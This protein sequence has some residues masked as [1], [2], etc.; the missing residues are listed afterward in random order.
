[1][2]SRRFPGKTLAPFRD[3]PV[4]RHVL[5]AVEDALPHTQIVVATSDDRSDDPLAA[6]LG[7]L[8]VAVFRGPLD[9]VFERFRL[10]AKQ[11]PSDWI[12][13][14][15]ADS[16]LLRPQV[17]RAV[18]AH[19]QAADCELVTTIFPRTWPK[20]ENAELIRTSTLLSVAP[21]ALSAEDAEHVTAYFYRHA[22]KFRIVNVASPDPGLADLQLAVDT[23]EDLH[24]LERLTEGQVDELLAGVLAPE[25]LADGGTCS[26]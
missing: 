21:G 3:R 6:Y 16:P 14:I 13:R 2:S 22:S 8:D 25:A 20:G 11:Y 12:L 5:A 24:R 4:I 26:A 15:S 10:C 7:S 17:L 18:V 19:A 23:V 1:M 9:N